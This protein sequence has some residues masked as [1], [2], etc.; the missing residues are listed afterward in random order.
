M[1]VK[2]WVVVSSKVAVVGA[3]SVYFVWRMQGK[4]E[5][6][7]NKRDRESVCESVCV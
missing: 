3:L 6:R 5:G 7:L 1:N 2:N 4:K